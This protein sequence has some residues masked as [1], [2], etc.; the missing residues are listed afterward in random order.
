VVVA[1]RGEGCV[2]GEL[3]GAL[4]PDGAPEFSGCKETD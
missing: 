2:G 1:E 3:D 4:R